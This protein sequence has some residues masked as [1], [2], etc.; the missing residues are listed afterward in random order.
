MGWDNELGEKRKKEIIENI[1]HSSVVNKEEYREYALNIIDSIIKKDFKRL[2]NLCN[3][4][5]KNDIENY[6]KRVNAAVIE[7]SKK[8]VQGCRWSDTK[9]KD[10]INGNTV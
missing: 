9:M 1:N 6:I 7:K 2:D 3:E 5:H 10:K 4:L 8:K